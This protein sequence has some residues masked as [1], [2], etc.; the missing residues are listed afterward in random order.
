[1]RKEL[2]FIVKLKS[3]D[4]R[5]K[6]VTSSHCEH[7]R[8]EITFVPM[9]AD[10]QTKPDRYLVVPAANGNGLQQALNQG[11]KEGYKALFALECRDGETVVVMEHE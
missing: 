3:L 2:L 8:N 7:P 9:A 4:S 10:T 5:I 6:T 11:D 1:M